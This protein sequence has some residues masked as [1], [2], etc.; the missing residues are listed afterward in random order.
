[1]LVYTFCSRTLLD[2]KLLSF[3]FCSVSC[4][5]EYVVSKIEI[6]SKLFFKRIVIQ[7]GSYARWTAHA[8]KS[9]CV[10]SRALNRTGMSETISETD[11]NKPYM[12]ETRYLLI[13]SEHSSLIASK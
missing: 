10:E 8:V 1:M 7:S 2:E 13:E 3:R 6:D 12:P 9:G 4:I 5:F 11:L